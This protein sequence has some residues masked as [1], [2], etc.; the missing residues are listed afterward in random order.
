M[1][2]PSNVC[3]SSERFGVNTSTEFFLPYTNADT[4]GFTPP[5]SYA[6]VDPA[7]SETIDTAGVFPIF[8]SPDFT[9][10]NY[11]SSTYRHQTYDSQ[12]AIVVSLHLN[13]AT[14]FYST[15]DK[16]PHQDTYADTIYSTTTLP[17]PTKYDSEVQPRDYTPHNTS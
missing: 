17:D 12:C 6:T 2:F 10:E 15:I 7:Y 13:T 11:E 3:S 16:I 8:Y 1:L 5:R 9:G 14:T 4:R